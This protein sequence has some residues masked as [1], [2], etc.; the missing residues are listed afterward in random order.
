MLYH[1]L[2]NIVS[3]KVDHPVMLE[4]CHNEAKFLIKSHLNTF[5]K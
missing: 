3:V 1:S 2:Q 5:Q 4:T